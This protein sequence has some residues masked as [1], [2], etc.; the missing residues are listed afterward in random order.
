MKNITIFELN[1]KDGSLKA[2]FE[3]N[4]QEI[5]M[6]SFSRKKYS[7]S[8]EEIISGNRY[9][10]M[11][12]EYKTEEDIDMDDF[13]FVNVSFKGKNIISCNA[14]INKDVKSISITDGLNFITEYYF[15]NTLWE[16]LKIENVEKG[17]DCVCL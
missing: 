6:E 2:R 1:S 16:E 17:L 14:Y 7:D 4:S 5:Q 15:S 3:T 8:L 9:V 10:Y 11:Y 13:S 12:H